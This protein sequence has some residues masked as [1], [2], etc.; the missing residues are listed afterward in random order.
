MGFRVDM[1]G[2]KAKISLI[3][4]NTTV[5]SYAAS[6]AARMMEQYVPRRTGALRASAKTEPFKVT[7]N[8]PYAV[9]QFYGRNMTH[10]TTP[11]TGSR[12]DKRLQSSRI[13]DLAR[14]ITG[15]LKGL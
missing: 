12:W 13:G 9:Y 5:G 7:Y 10:Y 1:S 8:A 11:N 14:S 15:F 3:C 4:S 2:A 6:E